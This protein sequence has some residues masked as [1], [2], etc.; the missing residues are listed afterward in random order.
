MNI[1]L[2]PQEIQ[3]L[4]ACIDVATKQGGIN[5]AATLL[6]TAQKLQSALP[7]DTKQEQPKEK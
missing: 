7:D 6:P 4:I 2:E 3:N 5:T 1:K